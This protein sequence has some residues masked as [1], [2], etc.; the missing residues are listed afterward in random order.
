MNTSKTIV[1]DIRLTRRLAAALA[2]ILVAIAILAYL[3]TNTGIAEASADTMPAAPASLGRQFYLSDTIHNG[4]EALTACTSGY[5][6]A[7]IWEIADPSNL[8]YNTTLGELRDDNGA[9]PPS[10]SRGWIRTGFSE[11]KDSDPGHGNCK[12]WR[13]QSSSDQ[14]TIALLID[15]WDSGF[16]DVN[17]WQ[18][19]YSE[20]SWKNHVWCVED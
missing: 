8:Q 14:G 3:V 6:F 4:V 20:C 10:G 11:S 5:H 13:S 19:S 9:G 2:G 15:R 7:S 18:A 16:Q 1:I 12:A 17:V